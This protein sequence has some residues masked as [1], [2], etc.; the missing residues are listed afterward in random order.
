MFPGKHVENINLQH[1]NRSRKKN[2]I[3]IFCMEVTNLEIITVAAI[4]PWKFSGFIIIIFF[5]FSSHLL[6]HGGEVTNT[7]RRYDS[8]DLR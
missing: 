5:Y 8:T 7:A 6:G 2:K 1:K 4:N 3:Y